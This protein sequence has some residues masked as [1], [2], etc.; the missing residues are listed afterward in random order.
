M[1]WALRG[2]VGV[3]R[4]MSITEAARRNGLHVSHGRK[5]QDEFG[6]FDT[7]VNISDI[8]RCWTLV[9]WSCLC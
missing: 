6:R 9:S 5:L 8:N 7:R 3:C 2:E 4:Y 1:C